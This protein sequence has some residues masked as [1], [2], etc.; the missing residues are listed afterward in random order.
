M[1]MQKSTPGDPAIV[2]RVSIT[3][4]EWQGEVC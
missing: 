1:M 2:A 4:L 3:A